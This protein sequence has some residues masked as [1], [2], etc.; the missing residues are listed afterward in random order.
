[1]SL[2]LQKFKLPNMSTD[3]PAPMSGVSR[4]ISEPARGVSDMPASP[5]LNRFASYDEDR[6]ARELNEGRLLRHASL[7]AVP[8]RRRPLLRPLQYQ[9]SPPPLPHASLD[10]HTYC[11]LVQDSTNH[12]G[13]IHIN[14]DDPGALP[15][16]SQ[17]LYRMPSH[18]LPVAPALEASPF[19]AFMSILNDMGFS[20]EEAEVALVYT[21]CLSIEEA[22]DFISNPGGIVSTNSYILLYISFIMFLCFYQM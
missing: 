10:V 20:Y 12:S 18:T 9:V 15:D 17:I 8:Q 4:S 22:I 2:F 21:K 16:S 1:M 13:E 6:I 3:L 7:R 5:A 11:L 19:A 14:I